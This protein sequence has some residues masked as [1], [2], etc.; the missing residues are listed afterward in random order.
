M[1]SNKIK[2]HIDSTSQMP[3]NH[4]MITNNKSDQASTCTRQVRKIGNLYDASGLFNLYVIA[5]HGINYY[6][7]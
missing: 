4:L 6:K 7:T 5:A 1:P 3:S 2:Y